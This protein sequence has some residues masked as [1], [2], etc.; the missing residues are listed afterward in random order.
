MKMKAKLCQTP[1]SCGTEEFMRK[2][3]K[4]N[5][6]RQQTCVSGKN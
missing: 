5:G 2:S 3:N 4:K 6:Y 1:M